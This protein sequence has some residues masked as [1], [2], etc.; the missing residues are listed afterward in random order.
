M[1]GG[2]ALSLI[3]F[4]EGCKMQKLTTRFNELSLLQIVST[5]SLLVTTLILL[6]VG[7][8][9]AGEHS[10]VAM[11][12][13]VIVCALIL[14]DEYIT[15]RIFF[16]ESRVSVFGKVDGV[17]FGKLVI[18]SLVSA[19]LLEAGTLFGARSAS[20]LL[21]E[22]W[23]IF[24]LGIFF[25]LSYTALLAVIVLAK[26][27]PKVFADD[28]LKRVSQR[29]LLVSVGSVVFVV[30]ASIAVSLFVSEAIGVS[31]L[32][33]TMFFIALFGT[34]VFFIARARLAKDH[35]EWFFVVPAI[36]F[37]SFIA[38]AP[39]ADTGISWDDQIHYER[40]L[41]LSYV[42]YSE[43][44]DADLTLFDPNVDVGGFPGK[45]LVGGGN[46]LWS[47]SEVE[48]YH[49]SI[50]K[51]NAE[52][53]LYVCDRFGTASGASIASYTAIGYLPAAMGLWL[54]RLMHLPFSLVFEL[55][56]WANL[57]AYCLITFFA[58]R[59]IPTKKILLC[60]IALLPTNLFLAAS[61]S[62]D[63]WLT[64]FLF[65]AVALVV[66]EICSPDTILRK[67]T[68]FALLLV[69]FM[70]LGPKAVYFPLIGLLFLLPKSKFVSLRERRHFII[71]VVVLG[72][73]VVSSFLLPFVASAGGATTDV[74]GGADVSSS[75]QVG[76]ILS[77]PV[78]YISTLMS[79]L[80]NDYLTIAGSNGY[81]LFFAYL[82]Q[83]QA[84]AP[85]LSGLPIVLLLAVA[86]TD[87]DSLSMRFARIPQAAWVAFL[88]FVTVC[89]IATALYVS[90]TPVGLGT[91]NGCQHRYLLPLLFPLFA[92]CLNF[93]MENNI[94]RTVYGMG[95]ISLATALVGSCCWV[96]IAAKITA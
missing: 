22:D 89:L 43:F 90:F 87:V 36:L 46:H 17:L 69:F 37:G 11:G 4:I 64:S 88:F 31:L 9:L 78:G 18:A 19:L 25:G 12:A 81:A 51:M 75:A 30:V 73:V 86:L 55:G 66:R 49:D 67:R 1:R 56:R 62:Y 54:G 28:C 79:F 6:V 52:G 85:W 42:A 21:L 76:F 13:Y 16:G 5:G 71:S 27:H 32:S 29:S 10:V 41:S 77:N 26:R 84:I 92:F 3:L 2:G 95:I 58:I 63:P 82:G 96:L 8:A 60:A 40:S 14:F 33:T 24:R 45:S 23:S 70:G 53:D 20:V 93:R 57:I 80:A 44:S 7:V 72:C 59:L 83:A 61:Y 39:P 91:I 74:R 35:I 15:W 68:R 34:A 50:N 48:K 47:E 65:L 38:F 94:N